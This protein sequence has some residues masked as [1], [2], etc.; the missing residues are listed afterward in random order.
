MIQW[1]AYKTFLKII[2][3]VIMKEKKNIVKRG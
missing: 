1:D 2:Y 3:N